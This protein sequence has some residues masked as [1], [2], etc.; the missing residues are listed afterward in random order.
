MLSSAVWS[1][2]LDS[3]IRVVPSNLR[4]SIILWKQDNDLQVLLLMIMLHRSWAEKSS[5]RRSPSS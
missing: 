3:M 4:Y 1:Q 2:E 5:Q